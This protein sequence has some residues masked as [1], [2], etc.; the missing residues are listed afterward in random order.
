LLSRF[1]RDEACHAFAHCHRWWWIGRLR[2]GQPSKREAAVE[3]AL[4]EAGRAFPPDRFPETL[5]GADRLGGGVEFDWGYLS[6][7]GELGHAIAAQSGKVLGGGSA[8]N[9]GVAKRAVPPTSTR[10]LWTRSERRSTPTIT[11]Q[12]RFQWAATPIMAERMA[13]RIAEEIRVAGSRHP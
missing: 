8:I 9:A 12:R 2:A 11:A 5:T 3:V 13:R 1:S 6:E 4:L 10:R 7:P